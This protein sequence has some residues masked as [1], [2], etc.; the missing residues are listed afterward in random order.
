M[1]RDR[2]D[3]LRP[4]GL[5]GALV[6]LVFALAVLAPMV[7]GPALVPLTQALGGADSHLCAC[8][9]ARGTCGCPECE[10]IE[11]ERLREHAPHSYPVLRAHCGEDDAATGSP[12]LPTAIAVAVGILLPASPYERTALLRPAEVPSR[13]PAEPATPPP[14]FVNA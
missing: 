2:L 13:D 4:R 14:R 12:A 7:L 11:H 1:S 9:M 10:K 3:A 8:G 6:A 5:A